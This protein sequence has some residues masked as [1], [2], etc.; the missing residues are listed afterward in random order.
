M[1]VKIFQ[2]RNNKPQG[3]EDYLEERWNDSRSIIHNPC[4]SW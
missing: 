1:A 4:C 2:K 3:N